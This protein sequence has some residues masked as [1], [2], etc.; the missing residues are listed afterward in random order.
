M[1]LHSVTRRW[2]GRAV[3]RCV[4]SGANIVVRGTRSLPSHG[5]TLRHAAL[6]QQRKGYRPSDVETLLASSCRGS[7]P[8]DATCSPCGVIQRACAAARAKRAWTHRR[9]SRRRQRAASANCTAYRGPAQGRRREQRQGRAPRP[10]P[11]HGMGMLVSLQPLR[12][13]RHALERAHPFKITR[14]CFA[15]SE[16]EPR[17]NVDVR[18]LRRPRGEVREGYVW[19]PQHWARVRQLTKL[20]R[21]AEARG[22]QQVLL[23]R[24]LGCPH[25]HSR[26]RELPELKC[27][28]DEH[29]ASHAHSGRPAR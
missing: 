11:A 14:V 20:L 18:R 3:D 23:C 13:P 25:C 17:N 26:V 1:F 19:R 4:E 2:I 16:H 24:R 6:G 12:L 21:C 27:M 29:G 7:R 10:P 15:Q 28:A 5:Q 8:F 22:A 9:S